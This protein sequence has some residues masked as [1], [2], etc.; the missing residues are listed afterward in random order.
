MQRFGSCAVALGAFALCL[1]SKVESGLFYNGV[2]IRRSGVIIR[3]MVVIVR[4]AVN[5]FYIIGVSV[6]CMG[7]LVR[8]F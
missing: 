6:G 3:C 2:S 5:C 8:L 7:V 4:C 1:E